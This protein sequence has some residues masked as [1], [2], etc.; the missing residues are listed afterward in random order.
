MDKQKIA[1]LEASLADAKTKAEE[2]GGS[3]DNLNSAV[4]EAE[5]ALTEAKSSSQDD[6]PLKKEVEKIENGKF[7]KKD[8]LL[9]AKKKI[10]E[11][12]SELDSEGI[13]K[14]EDKD[15]PVTVGMLEDIEKSKAQKTALKLAESIE[16]ENERTLTIYNLENV[17]RPSGD[18]Q[19]DLSAARAIVNSLKNSQIIEEVERK[20]EGKKFPT[21]P[22]HSPKKPGDVFEP[23]AQERVF[24]SPPYNLSQKDI[25]KAR[26][27]EQS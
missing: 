15:K 17:I 6:D 19:K 3:D 11:Q 5:K 23:T 1:T 2:A 7:T 14:D 16:D 12:L 21:P 8:R 9:H 10:E 4:K 20:K 25:E 26:E 22:G 24:M 27:A 18:P 13:P